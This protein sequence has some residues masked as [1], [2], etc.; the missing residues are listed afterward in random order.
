[1]SNK[2]NNKKD[3]SRKTVLEVFETGDSLGIHIDKE[4]FIAQGLDMDFSSDEARNMSILS[5]LML[6]MVPG[7]I[8]HAR[9]SGRSFYETY[10]DFQIG[11]AD[12]FAIEM[13]SH[14]L[15]EDERDAFNSEQAALRNPLADVFMNDEGNVVARL[16][17]K[18]GLL[19][20]GEDCSDDYVKTTDIGVSLLCGALSQVLAMKID[21]GE[22]V[23]E[24]MNYAL[25]S[26]ANSISNAVPGVQMGIGEAPIER[27]PREIFPHNEKGGPMPS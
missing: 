5:A 9:A 11:F 7:I 23:P 3:D 14:D 10:K 21:A 20:E 6:V 26:F 22:G 19:I 27:V 18:V 16:N 24:V 1:M 4:A 13:Q 17:P 2:G 8:K 12:L 25:T 15:A